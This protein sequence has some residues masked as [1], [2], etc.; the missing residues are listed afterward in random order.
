MESKDALQTLLHSFERYYT[1]KTDG[2]VAPFSAEAEFHSHT[3]QFFL[4]R[5]A[6]IADIDSNEFVFFA[7]EGQL[8]SARLTELDAAAWQE[9]L[10][11]VRPCAGHRNSD[12]TLIVLADKIDDDAFRQIKR[13]KHSKS[14]K[15]TLHGW[16]NFRALAY[17]VS[18]GRVTYNRFGKDLKK[19]VG[20]L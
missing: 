13:L 12:V 7:E 9:G 10:S 3:E 17:E 14:Y 20:S 11:R 16:S 2:V 5:A 1:V 15:F 19:L 4:V 18:S 8:T 6:H